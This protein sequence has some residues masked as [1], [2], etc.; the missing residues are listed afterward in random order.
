MSG[1]SKWA[2]IK[3]QK[4]IADSR[5]GA[6]F[7]KL[8]ILIS[9]A[10]RKG[11]DPEMNFS[12]RLAI[13]KA[14]AANMPAA[15]IEKAIKRGAGL[16]GGAAMEEITYEGYGPGGVAILVECATDNRNRTAAEIRAA[17]SKHG[18]RMAETGSVSYLF[19]HRGVIEIQP[20]YMEAAT[21][22][23]IEAGADDISEEGESLIVYTAPNQLD[24]VRKGLAEA[25]YDIKSAEFTFEP[26]QTTEIT[27]EKT[28][29]TLMKLVDVLEDSDDVSNTYA[30][31][32]ISE[33]I[34]GKL[35]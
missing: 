15:G 11:A 17:F 4:G 7:T 12:L 35:N 22:A 5:R 8:S 9:L 6:A 32:E 31:F 29:S 14:K 30:N 34:T 10:A 18:G 19:T 13:T 27:D 16:D 24:A 2:S 28:A 21:L 23:S 25:G 26:G 33:A 1:H 3:H 20:K